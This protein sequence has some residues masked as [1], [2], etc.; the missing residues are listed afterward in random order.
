M[1]GPRLS[2]EDRALIQAGLESGMSVRT[3]AGELGRAPST[4]SREVRRNR[5]TRGYHC[6]WAQRRAALK[7]RRPKVFKL[8]GTAGSESR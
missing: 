8:R 2:L 7:S 4:I 1:P 3:V 6:K 5:S